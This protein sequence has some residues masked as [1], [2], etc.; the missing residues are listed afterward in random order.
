MKNFY[1]RYLTILSNLLFMCG[2]KLSAQKVV[3]PHNVFWSK[4]EITQLDKNYQ[5]G[6]GADVVYRRKSGLEDKSMFHVPLR[7]SVRPWVHYQFSPNARLS[8]SPIGYVRNHEYLAKPE[9]LL[10]PPNTE[11]RT[12]LQYFHHYKPGNPR[13]MH[14]WR[15]RY[16]M[17]WQEVPL[18]D[19]WRFI[20]RFRI[21]YRLRYTLKGSDFYENNNIYAMVSNE[22]G[23]N[24]GKNVT[25]NTFN[26]NRFYAGIG[27]R[28]LNTVRAEVRYVN[29]I[30]TRG[31]TGFEFDHGRGLMLTLYIDQLKGLGKQDA[32]KIQFTD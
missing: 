29:R 8:L 6:W 7:F 21:R 16:E 30:R 26:Q 1:I 5:W 12:T 24:F 23:L 32:Y 27:Y 3:Y 15:Y 19:T 4:T 13:F 9:D 11:W 28:F 2:S 10:R 22:I 20:N 17:R 31:A 18:Q 25:F 14:T